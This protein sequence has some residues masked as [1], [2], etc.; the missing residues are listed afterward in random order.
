MRPSHASYQYTVD[1]PPLP[2]A[3]KK[4][5]WHRG[6]M[7]KGR[8]EPVSIRRVAH[9]VAKVKGLPVEEVTEA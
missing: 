1:A 4:E 8:N 6:L 7:V 3:V 2:M 9:A 5:K